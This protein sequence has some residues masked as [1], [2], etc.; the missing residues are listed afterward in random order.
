MAR[1]PTNLLECEGVVDDLEVAEPDL[2][3]GRHGEREDV[4]D[5]G[6]RPRMEVRGGEDLNHNNK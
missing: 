1:P 4:V 5:E 6:L 3:I 2:P